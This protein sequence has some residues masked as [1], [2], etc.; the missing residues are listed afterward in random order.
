MNVDRCTTDVQMFLDASRGHHGRQ[1]RVSI[2]IEDCS[3]QHCFLA[4]LCLAVVGS[5]KRSHFDLHIQDSTTIEDQI[6]ENN[7]S[8]YMQCK[9]MYIYAYYAYKHR[10][11]LFQP[12]HLHFFELPLLTFTPFLAFLPILYMQC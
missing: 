6:N 2:L 8:I 5:L 9:K 4:F 10:F 7:E 12:T 3:P 1:R 11:D